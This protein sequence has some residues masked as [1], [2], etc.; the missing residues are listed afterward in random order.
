MS[1]PSQEW[2]RVNPLDALLS[3]PSGRSARPRV[4]VVAAHLCDVIAAAGGHLGR[5][6][7][8]ELVHTTV[9]PGCEGALRE[10]VSLA[11]DLVFCI[12]YPAQETPA[13]LV[14]LTAAARTIFTSLHPDVVVT[15][16]Y[17]GGD[18]DRD[19]VAFAV[20]HATRGMLQPPL[21]VE[22]TG[23]NAANGMHSLGEFLHTPGVPER[24]S[25]LT[26]DEQARKARALTMF[27]EF[28]ARIPEADLYVEHFRMAPRYDFTQPPHLGTLLYEAAGGRWTGASWRAQ[29]ARAL[30][31]VRAK[32][33]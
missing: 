21:I 8:A 4:V 18:C 26:P 32:E 6:N 12:G 23:W 2:P 10:V 13:H 1:R 19:A 30:P 29:A 7:I 22:M 16:A 17:E 24:A 31:Q 11:P 25:R 20:H 14:E 15:Q 28:R 3:W 9:S 5:W 27:P 33:K